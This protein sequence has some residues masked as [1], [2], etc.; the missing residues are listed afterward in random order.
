MELIWTVPEK[1]VEMVST[2]YKAI[3]PVCIPQFCPMRGIS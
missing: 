1:R 2:I 3:L